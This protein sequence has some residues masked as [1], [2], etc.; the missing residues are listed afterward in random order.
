MQGAA[1]DGWSAAL[2]GRG[3]VRPSS[4]VRRNGSRLGPPPASVQKL[5][6]SEEV[7]LFLLTIPIWV[8]LA[9]VYGL[10]ERDEERPTHTTVDD[11]V[12]VFNLVTVGVWAIAVGA[13]ATK[14]ATPEFGRLAFFWATAIALLVIARST[15]RGIV[16]RTSS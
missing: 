3:Y 9:K 14:W 13:W 7:A 12:G 4:R 10:Y 2:S 15:A 16:R 6:T 11:L 5:S 8:V 1:A